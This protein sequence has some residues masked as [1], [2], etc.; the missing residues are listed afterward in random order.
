M[1]DFLVRENIKEIDPY[2]YE[3]IRIEEELADCAVFPEDLF[4]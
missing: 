2:L 3:L 1:K 4:I